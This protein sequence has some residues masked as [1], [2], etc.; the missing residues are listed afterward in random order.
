[1]PSEDFKIGNLSVDIILCL[2]SILLNKNAALDFSLRLI[3]GRV[4]GLAES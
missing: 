1:M 3:F 2:S 4:I